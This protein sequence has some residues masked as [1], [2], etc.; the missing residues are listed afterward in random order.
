MKKEIY[1][2]PLEFIRSSEGPKIPLF[3]VQLHKMRNRRNDHYM[4]RLVLESTDWVNIV[5]VTPSGE[6]VIVYQYRS[7]VDNITGEIPGGMVDAGEESLAAA[8]RELQEETGYTTQEWRY[9]GAVEPNPA[10]HNNLCHHWLASNVV[11]TADIS[12]DD[13]EDIQV[14]CLTMEEIR[15]EMASGRFS[16][17]LALSALSRVPEIWR[18]I[19]P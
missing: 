6:L 11:K 15:A 13:G 17:S 10:I 18:Q 12:L 9:L 3:T 7:G 4:T 19:C 5:A 16:H 14:E 8:K 2:Q 1:I